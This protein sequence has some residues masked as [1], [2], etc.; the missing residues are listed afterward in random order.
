[1]NRNPIPIPLPMPRRA[2]RAHAPS[3]LIDRLA[4]P[5]PYITGLAPRTRMRLAILR[6]GSPMTRPSRRRLR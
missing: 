2:G 4:F 3:A 5:P 6:L 1:M